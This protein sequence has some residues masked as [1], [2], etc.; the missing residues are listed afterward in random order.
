MNEAIAGDSCSAEHK[1]LFKEW[2]ENMLDADKT[3]ELAAKIIPLVEGAK[4]KCEHCRQIAELKHYLV[5]R[6]QWIIGGDGA[7]YDIGYG[8]S[9]T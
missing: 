4:D 8:V 6:S 2:I 3:K 5:K 1:E 9:T 7:S